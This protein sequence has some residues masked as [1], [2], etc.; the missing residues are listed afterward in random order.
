MADRETDPKQ[1]R[2]DV[3]KWMERVNQKF[4]LEEFASSEN[5]RAG[6]NY[7]EK[8]AEGFIKAVIILPYQAILFLS[9]DKEMIAERNKFIEQHGGS[10][11]VDFYQTHAGEVVVLFKQ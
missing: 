3:E 5:E 1:V 7:K 8:L 11:N 6:F 9:E 2:Q 4:P 10:E